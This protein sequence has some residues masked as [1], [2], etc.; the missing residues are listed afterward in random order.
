MIRYMSCMRK[1]EHLSADEFRRFWRD[2]SFDDL[3]ERLVSLV[4]PMRFSKS[5][6]LH[7]EA[8]TQIMHERG[9]DEPFDGIIEYWWENAAQVME[10]VDTPQAAELLDQIHLYKS[11]FVD[12]SRSS[13]FFT[14]ALDHRSTRVSVERGE[15]P[16]H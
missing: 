14:E 4:K 8:N 10:V 7:V 13:I 5:L 12:F 15:A 2:P 9:T 6:V 11:Q 1:L 3:I 16:N